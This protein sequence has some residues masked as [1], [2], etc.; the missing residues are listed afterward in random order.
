MCVFL[1]DTDVILLHYSFLSVMKRNVWHRIL[2]NAQFNDH[3]YDYN[4]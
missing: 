4:C 2:N 3:N 1:T